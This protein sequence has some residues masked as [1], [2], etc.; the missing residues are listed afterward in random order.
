MDIGQDDVH[1]WRQGGLV[2]SAVLQQQRR[3]QSRCG[4]GGLDDDAFQAFCDL[5]EDV[6]VS[7]HEVTRSSLLSLLI[8]VSSAPMM[9]TVGVAI[10][11]A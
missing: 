2:L 5:V 8:M 10:C 1:A 4:S 3:V 11:G 7:R 9:W 6:E